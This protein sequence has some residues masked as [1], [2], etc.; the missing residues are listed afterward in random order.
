M[1][2]GCGPA[3]ADKW[4]RKGFRTIDELRECNDL[5]LTETQRLGKFSNK[6]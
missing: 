6:V 4:Y 1:V 5:T 3:T 2:Y